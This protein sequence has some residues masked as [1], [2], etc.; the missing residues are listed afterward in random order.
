MDGLAKLQRDLQSRSTPLLVLET[1]IVFLNNLVA[2][3]GNLLTL[4]VVL[5]SPRLRTIPSKF[6]ISLA[7]SDILMAIPSAVLTT[8]VSA[9]SDW[10][11][12][13]ATCQI[14]GYFGIT[15]AFASSETLALMSMNR[16][17]RVVKPTRYRRVFAQRRTSLMIFAAWLIA[18]LVQLPYVAVGHRFLFHPGKIYCNQDGKEPFSTILVSVFGGI[19]MS[20]I[21]F[22]SF[23]I[24]RSVRAHTK[25][26]FKD[27]GSTRVNVED[28]KVSR[29][30]LVMVLANII[31][32]SP[33]II[34]EAIDFFRHGSYLPRP[35]Y[36]F[37][38][39][40]ATLSSSVNPIIYGA[41]NRSFRKEYIRL[42]RLDNCR[43]FSVTRVTPMIASHTTGL[44][45]L[46][47]NPPA[48]SIHSPLATNNNIELK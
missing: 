33:V 44:N 29:I 48:R 27:V 3:V 34:I 36:L 32:F 41:M 42:L 24:F 4:I 17:Y 8:T 19:P 11:F 14:Q 39:I 7:I 6:V 13:S 43:M 23:K 22:C 5:R 30:L 47:I 46:G 31:C 35:I 10:P 18:S 28:I 40:A 25:T 9:K 16:Y 38:T 2:S 37:Y 1:L 15:L 45:L 26:R 20:V 12:G 21:S